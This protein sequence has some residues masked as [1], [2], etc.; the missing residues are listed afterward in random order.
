MVAVVKVHVDNTTVSDEE[1]T[2]LEVWVNANDSGEIEYI[3]VGRGA[4][5][6]HGPRPRH[7]AGVSAAQVRHS[8]CLTDDLDEALAAMRTTRDA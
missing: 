5:L 7:N 2:E 6:V 3:A 1:I 8:G 4:V